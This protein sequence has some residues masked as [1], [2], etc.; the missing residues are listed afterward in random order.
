[1]DG[2]N[3]NHSYITP[4]KTHIA[5][6]VAFVVV[7]RYGSLVHEY[8]YTGNDVVVRFIRELLK[9]EEI[10]VNTTKFNKYMIFDKK[11]RE[12]FSQATVCHI[13]N[14]KRKNRDSKENPF[15]QED[16]KVR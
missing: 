9:C 5:I 16:P 3:C 10:L 15:T 7:D 8:T 6:S 14:N 2:E 1:M 12:S 4:I 11:D 13:C